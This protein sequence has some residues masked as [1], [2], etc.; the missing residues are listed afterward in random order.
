ME[1]KR[2]TTNEWIEPR[3]GMMAGLDNK[4]R[5][6]RSVNTDKRTFV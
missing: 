2:S 1:W 6:G 4:E 3:R 5:G